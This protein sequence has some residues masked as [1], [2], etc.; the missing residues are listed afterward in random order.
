MMQTNNVTKT[1]IAGLAATAVMTMVMIMAPMM[2]MPEMNIGKMLGEFM[3]VPVVVGW[4]AHF[5]IGVVLAFVFAFVF[6][7]RLPG[8]PVVRGMLFGLIPW[9]V[10]QVVMNPMMGAGVFASNTP[11]P[12]MMVM[13][14][15]LGHLV[16]G[17]VLGGVYGRG[18]S[19]SVAVRNTSEVH[20][21]Q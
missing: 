2:G 4:L 1:I 17:A 21:Q 9:L 12:M 3:G 18:S 10:A 16:Y 20:V 6:F 8:S 7:S 13:G 19:G 5:M 14:S 15:L 11:A